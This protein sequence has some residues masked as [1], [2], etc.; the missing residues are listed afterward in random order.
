MF[1]LSQ[2]ISKVSRKTEFAPPKMLQSS[3]GSDRAKSKERFSL[4][5]SSTKNNMGIE[6]FKMFK[7]CEIHNYDSKLSCSMFCI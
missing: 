6:I 3:C 5:N 4:G 2:C 7:A 1:N